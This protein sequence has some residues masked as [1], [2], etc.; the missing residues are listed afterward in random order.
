MFPCIVYFTSV[1]LLS[2]GLI[3]GSHGA[4]S[5]GHRPAVTTILE[6]HDNREWCV[7][8]GSGLQHCDKAV[9]HRVPPLRSPFMGDPVP[10]VNRHMTAACRG[11]H[12]LR[13]VTVSPLVY[14]LKL[15]HCLLS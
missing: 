8:V 6:P 4:Q 7:R 9:L 14:K 15:A 11:R 1:K 10:T 2:M 5:V 3:S 13:V 12:V